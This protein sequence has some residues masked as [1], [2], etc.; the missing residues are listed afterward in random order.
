MEETKKK[1]IK[2]LSSQDTLL[3]L[4]GQLSVSEEIAKIL[5]YNFNTST[6]MWLN[7]QNEYDKKMEMI[8]EAKLKDGIK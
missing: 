3:L 4:S 2:G 8:N 7:L 6:Q 5:A 1:E